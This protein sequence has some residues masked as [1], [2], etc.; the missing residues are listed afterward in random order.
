[1]GI[2]DELNT[3]TLFGNAQATAAEINRPTKDIHIEKKNRALMADTVLIN[4]AAFRDGGPI[5]GT[6]IIETTT[7]TDDDRYTLFQPEAGSVYRLNAAGGIATNPSSASYTMYVTN[8]PIGGSDI[9]AFFYFSADDT[10]VLFT[11]D[12]NWGPYTFDEN[13]RI[14]GYVGGSVD[15]FT[16]QLNLFRV[17]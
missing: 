17:R 1:M 15:S 9:L 14:E 11:G 3:R 12:A 8:A 6:S 2:W 13:V 5:P 16:W 4:K 10:T 7:V